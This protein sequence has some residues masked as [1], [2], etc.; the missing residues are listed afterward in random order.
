MLEHVSELA[1][2]RRRAFEERRRFI[3]AAFGFPYDG[4]RGDESVALSGRYDADGVDEIAGERELVGR[5]AHTR[6]FHDVVQPR[7]GIIA[8]DGG[9]LL[10]E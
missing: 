3:V 9:E 5:C 10:D 7:D 1:P 6:S 2:G 8:G 4:L